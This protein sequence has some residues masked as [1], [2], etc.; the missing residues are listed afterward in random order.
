MTVDVQGHGHVRVSKPLIALL[1]AIV[2]VTV[3]ALLSR[4]GAR[5]LSQD[6][7]GH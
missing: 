6:E 5:R 7:T 3:G 1:A 4:P 2:G